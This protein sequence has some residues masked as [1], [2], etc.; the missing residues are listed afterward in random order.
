[1]TLDTDLVLYPFLQTT[2]AGTSGLK[3]SVAINVFTRNILGSEG[4]FVPGVGVYVTAPGAPLKVYGG[5][6]AYR[7]EEKDPEVNIVAGFG[8]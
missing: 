1:V 7:G 6:N 2:D 8:F 5:I 4:R 3:A